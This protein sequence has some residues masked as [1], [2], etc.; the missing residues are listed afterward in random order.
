MRPTASST[1][2]GIVVSA[3]LLAAAGC[4][5]TPSGGVNDGE[6]AAAARPSRPAEPP[7]AP[8]PL[9]PPEPASLPLADGRCPAPHT[10]RF[11]L[12]GLSS[13]LLGRE[14]DDVES[15][16]LAGQVAKV[17][18]AIPVPT[19]A[20]LPMVDGH[21]AEV[22]D[23]QFGVDVPVEIRFRDGSRARG[24]LRL[25]GMTLRMRVDDVLR[26][27]AKGPVALPGDTPRTADKPRSM[28][29]SGGVASPSLRG[30]AAT[31]RDVDWVLLADDVSRPA[32][33][34]D[35]STVS[36]SDLRARVYERRTG[37]VVA[38]RVF[39]SRDRDGCESVIGER[40]AEPGARWAWDELRLSR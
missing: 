19:E 27:V 35:G 17:A 18:D 2:H 20:L 25:G 21:L 39:P 13:R 31:I 10:C 38:E 22:A 24:T 14:A 34:P 26:G 30:V 33:C 3:V 15:V 36:I 16:S 6:L 4:G 5:A 8:A 29:V 7:T 23:E 11:K 28:W 9:P 12:E 32:R 37:M 40:N 1:F